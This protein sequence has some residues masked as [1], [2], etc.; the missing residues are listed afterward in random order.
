M[1]KL[2]QQGWGLSIFL[3]FIVVFLIAIILISIG[4]QKMGIA[5]GSN[6]ISSFPTSDSSQDIHY[7]EL[8]INHAKDYERKVQDAMFRY[9]SQIHSNLGAI[10]DMTVSV[11]KL[12]EYGYLEPLRVVGNLCNGYG[13]SHFNNENLSVN[14]FIH[15]GDLYMTEGYNSSLES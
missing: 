9:S 11:S 1:K 6:N 12:I 14:A 2:N 3:T 7:T 5:N 8:E 4:A 15:C 13:V 10:D